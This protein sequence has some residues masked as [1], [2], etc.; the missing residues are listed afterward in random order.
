MA[1]S[2]GVQQHLKMLC[3]TMAHQD[4]PP[5]KHS[6]LTEISTPV[7]TAEYATPGTIK[8]D[9]HYSPGATVEHRNQTTV[10]TLALTDLTVFIQPKYNV[11]L[12]ASYTWQLTNTL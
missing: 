1:R 10:L 8:L 9:N 2:Y 11:L 6:L 7:H 4:L 3:P 12:T 5:I